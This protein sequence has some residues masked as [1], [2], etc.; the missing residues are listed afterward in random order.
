MGMRNAGWGVLVGMML[1]GSS[2][3]ANEDVKYVDIDRVV[4]LSWGKLVTVY[5]QPTF[6][7]LTFESDAAITVLQIGLTWDNKENTYRP[8]VKQVMSIKK[9]VGP[10]SATE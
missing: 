3:G 2:I 9:V 10:S 1:L 5:D 4:Q 6:Q 7:R 8:A